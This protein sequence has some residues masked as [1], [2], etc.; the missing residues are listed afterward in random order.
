MGLQ[1]RG[2]MEDCL[3][4]SHLGNRETPS[5]Q[6]TSITPSPPSMANKHKQD[7]LI[8]SPSITGRSQI[9]IELDKLSEDDSEEEICEWEFDALDKDRHSRS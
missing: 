6:V 9:G 5:S 8:N 1:K 2:R 4:G 3:E 7:G